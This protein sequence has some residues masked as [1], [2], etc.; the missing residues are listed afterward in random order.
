MDAVPEGP[1]TS[2]RRC[3]SSGEASTLTVG[4]W[5]VTIL[6]SVAISSP[7]FVVSQVI[8]QEPENVV[9]EHL[10]LG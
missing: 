3:S 1:K 6:P 4:H 5:R 7:H 2:I 9:E 10:V 8:H